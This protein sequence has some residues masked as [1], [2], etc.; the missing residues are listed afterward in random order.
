MCIRDRIYAANADWPHS[1]VRFW[2]AY[3]PGSRWRWM[4][5]DLDYAFSLNAA[6]SHNT[7]RQALSTKADNAYHSLILRKL[8]TNTEFRALFAQRFAAHLNTTYTPALSLI[9]I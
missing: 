9:H 8:W 7:L 3:A 2:R 4:L 6:P 5:F 1:N